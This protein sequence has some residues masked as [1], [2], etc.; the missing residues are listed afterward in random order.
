MVR[1]I[2]VKLPTAAAVA[3][4]L[5]LT[6]A[7]GGDGGGDGDKK[8]LAA[9][10]AKVCG[11][12]VTGKIDASQVALNDISLV[13]P[14]ETPE[15][16]K[17]RLVGDFTKLAD[18]NSAFASALQVA[19]DPKV[20]DAE[21]QVLLLG[22][23]LRAN[24]QGW[25]AAKAELEALATNDQKAFADGLRALQPKITGSVTSSHAALDKLHTGRL[26][27][28]LAAVPG[29]VGSASAPPPSTP[30]APTPSETAPSA[31]GS[32]VAAPSGSASPSSSASGSASPSST[33]SGSAAPDDSERP[34]A[35]ASDSSSP[36]ADPSES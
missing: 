1:K 31:S 9:W 3:A 18:A 29:C 26:G 35:T 33:G 32:P 4:V 25:N 17:A 19:G 8:A 22:D 2:P 36:S 6:A 15:A 7:C 16:L 34:S 13:I 24:A 21:E 10:A 12:E 23:E 27:Q 20:K 14:G 30:P 11:E 5:A 28:A